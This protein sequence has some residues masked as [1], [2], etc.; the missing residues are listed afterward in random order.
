MVALVPGGGARVVPLTAIG[1][2]LARHLG[3]AA[4]GV[5]VEVTDADGSSQELTG[6]VPANRDVPVAELLDGLRALG[7]RLD[8]AF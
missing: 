6:L 4:G 8:V 5:A 2:W 3:S 1:V 7:I